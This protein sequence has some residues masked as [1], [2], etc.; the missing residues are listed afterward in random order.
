MSYYVLPDCFNET[1]NDD[2]NHLV[3]IYFIV[4]LICVMQW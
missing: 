3:D 2:R 1:E 4:V